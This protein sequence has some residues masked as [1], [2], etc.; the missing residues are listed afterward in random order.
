MKNSTKKNL[1]YILTAALIFGMIYFIEWIIYYESVYTHFGASLSEMLYTILL[2]KGMKK[3][4]DKI[5]DEEDE[6]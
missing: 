3:K 1:M 2:Y 4:I 5:G 6:S